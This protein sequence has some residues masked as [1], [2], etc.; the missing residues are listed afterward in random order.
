MQLRA[1]PNCCSI[2]AELPVVCAV[3]DLN[4]V[5]YDVIL[6][7]DV[8][9][10]LKNLPSISVSK[11]VPRVSVV[12]PVTSD[13]C[14]CDVTDDVDSD[15]NDTVVNVDQLSVDD[16]NGDADV[17][18]NQQLKDVS[19]K[20][21]WKMAKRGKGGYVISRGVLYQKDKVEGQS[22]CQLCVVNYVFL[23]ADAVMFSS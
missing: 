8:V 6:P 3:V 13:I 16:T 11:P 2:S 9:K 12:D 23:N 18:I 22:V 15:D 4:A 19:L 17:L 10:Q 20:D 7:D 1:A 5:E 14:K 21:C